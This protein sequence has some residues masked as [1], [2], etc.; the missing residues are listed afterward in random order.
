MFGRRGAFVTKL[1][2]TLLLTV[3]GL[4]GL[5]E[6]NVLLAYVLYTL[7]WQRSLETP[8]RNEVDE[9]DFSRG[10]VAITGALLVGLVLIPML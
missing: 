8:M 5:D 10:L 4:F 7:V 9:I 1:F 2:T 3:A 6:N